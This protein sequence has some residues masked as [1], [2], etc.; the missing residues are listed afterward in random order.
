MADPNV[1]A[2]VT[3]A[4]GVSAVGA[5]GQNVPATSVLLAGTI[6]GKDASGNF[7]LRTDNGNLLLQ[8]NLTLTYNNDVV[9]RADQNGSQLSNAKIVTVNGSPV[10][11]FAH[12]GQQENDS[13]SNALL[14]RV[15]PA[16]V[17]SQ[18][19]GTPVLTDTIPA[20]VVASP[21]NIPEPQAQ[22]EQ[23]VLANGA[24]IVIRLPD[25]NQPQQP[26]TQQPLSPQPAVIQVPATSPPPSGSQ[27]GAAQEGQVTV[28]AEPIPG[29]PVNN[30]TSADEIKI[31]QVVTQTATPAG[32]STNVP[33]T[34]AAQ[35]TAQPAPAPNPL[36]AAY[37]KQVVVTLQQSGSQSAPILAAVAVSPTPK[38]QGQV[39]TVGKDGMVTVQTPMG[40]VTLKA[41]PSPGFAR[42]LPGM[43]I[44]L[45][46]PEDV[47]QMVATTA[48]QSPAMNTVPASFAEIAGSWQT[49]EDIVNII[50]QSLSSVQ[51]MGGGQLQNSLLTN[52]PKLGPS[53]LSSSLSFMKAL[54]G[55]D[56]NK[57]LGDDTVDILKQSG[58]T[59]LLQKFTAELA[60]LTNN[61]TIK[62]EQQQAAGW[63]AGIL[64][65]VYQ[66]EVQQARVYVKRDGQQGKKQQ[67][68]NKSGGVRFVLE[69][70]LSEFGGIQMD[71]LIRQKQAN[72]IF[73][74][75]IR[76][77]QSF[78]PLEQAEITAIYASAAQQTGFRG[79][80]TFQV[81]SN[82]PAKPLDEIL[83]NRTSTITV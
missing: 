7:L 51:N 70:S 13:V 28:Q 27:A 69:V 34:Q 66:G 19:Q 32:G 75:M 22:G 23:A 17:S 57:I 60:T 78:S 65:F 26:D 76:S 35:A 46:L 82:F 72:T 16:P 14:A 50:N 79:S 77:N 1:V 15:N 5:Q 54:S 36:Y 12:P 56:V 41:E 42:L 6:V 80:I 63:Q 33:Q 59:D 37:A 39:I 18:A 29:N 4:T 2:P 45:E 11:E 25:S 48:S 52:L 24:S 61:F 47:N 64:P 21:D 83:A 10:A 3:Q 81:T 67:G 58:H 49:L 8:S 9:I 20:V 53:F 44:T 62:P 43:N 74:L 55:G 40:T 31:Q 38:V 30:V 68:S 73:D 71:G